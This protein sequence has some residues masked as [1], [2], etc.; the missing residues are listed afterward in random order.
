MSHPIRRHVAM[1]QRASIIA[2]ALLLHQ[3][4][5]SHPMRLFQP[6]AIP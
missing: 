4:A 2:M 3:C 6:I 5:A 1:P